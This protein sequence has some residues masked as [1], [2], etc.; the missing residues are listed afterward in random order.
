MATQGKITN[1]YTDKSM[2]TPAFPRTKVKAI[3]DDNGVG[4]DTVL[5]NLNSKI[6]NIDFD[7][8]GCPEG[9]V[10]V[11][12]AQADSAV[13]T[14]FEDK[15]KTVPIFPTTKVKAISN[16]EGIGL[17]AL[18]SDVV[19]TGDTDE[20]IETVPLN[21]DTLEGHSVNSLLNKI[22]FIGSE[23]ITSTPSNPSSY[24]GGTWELVGKG[25]IDSYG[26]SSN[27]SLFTA[28]ACSAH[29]ISYS[30]SGSTLSVK[31]GFTNST[32]LTDTTVSLGT[33]NFN[34]LGISQLPYTIHYAVG[35]SDG[36]NVVMMVMINYTTGE[37]SVVDI[38][39][40]DTMSASSSY[41]NFTVACNYQHMLDDFCNK[42]YWKR[43]A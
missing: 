5:D 32:D 28:T 21:A 10:F 33:L 19:Y 34:A 16:D 23:Y 4:L 7:S 37:V 17:D 41:A 24:L 18:I 6:D 42:F 40:D 26:S 12:E 36:G 27:G 2:A 3:S 9:V 14:L 35:T 15:A 39:G 43:T 25:F 8:L 29:T 13:A 22:Y 11:G 1:L 38:V 30:R 20:E 31:I